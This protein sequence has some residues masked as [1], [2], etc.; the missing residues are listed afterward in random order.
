M[1]N[2]SWR[3]MS[4]A[5]GLA[6]AVGATP[7]MATG[8]P[9]PPGDAQAG[10][11]AFRQC[12]TCHSFDPARR[13]MGP[14]LA[15]LHGRSAGAVEGFRYS[16]AMSASGVVWDDETLSAYL[17]DPRGYM[18]GTSMMVGLLRAEQLGD[19]LAYLR[20]RTGEGL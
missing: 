1:I 20:T 17:T 9:A 15:S 2:R 13:M 16:D 12:A 4:A 8:K 19:L 10:E 3:V 6:L 11:R 7:A 14:H 5:A 18:P